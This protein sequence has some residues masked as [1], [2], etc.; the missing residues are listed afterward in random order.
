[1]TWHIVGRFHKHW[2]L[3]TLGHECPDAKFVKGFE[4]HGWI[5]VFECKQINYLIQINLILELDLRYCIN[6]LI[7][8]SILISFLYIFLEV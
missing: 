6:I 3:E 8:I 1:M 2:R 7:F 5:K 4:L